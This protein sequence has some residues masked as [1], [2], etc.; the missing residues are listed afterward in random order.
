MNEKISDEKRNLIHNYQKILCNTLDISDQYIN[1]DKYISKYPYHEGLLFKILNI[2]YF[3]K[4]KYI[5]YPSGISLNKFKIDISNIEILMKEILYILNNYNKICN[6]IH[7]NLLLDNIL[8][9]NNN[10]IFIKFENSY[11]EYLDEKFYTKAYPARD[12]FYLIIQFYYKTKCDDCK[13]FLE[14]MFEKIDDGKNNSLDKIIK[15]KSINEYKNQI[16]SELNYNDFL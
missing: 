16:Y 2:N 15:N 5:Y 7:N 13:L 11:Y 4:D 9:Y 8:L 14:K 1:Y 6:F 3:I 12:V 10:I